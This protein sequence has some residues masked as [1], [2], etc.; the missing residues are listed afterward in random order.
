MLPLKPLVNEVWT[1][2]YNMHCEYN[3]P[4]ETIRRIWSDGSMTPCYKWKLTYPEYTIHIFKLEHGGKYCIRITEDIEFYRKQPRYIN[5]D[6]LDPYSVLNI[7]N[8]QTIKI[9]GQCYLGTRKIP[10][11]QF[12][13]IAIESKMLCNA[14][15]EPY[16]LLAYNTIYKGL[17]CTRISIDY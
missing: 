6:K 17:A 10:I 15:I 4:N 12:A 2:D 3:K 9:V 14:I 16:A 13:D 5:A 7:I 1:D 11:D 8:S